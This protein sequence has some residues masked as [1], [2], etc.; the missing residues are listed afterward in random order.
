MEGEQNVSDLYGA[1]EDPQYAIQ[2]QAQR[3]LCG[4]GI[5]RIRHKGE[6]DRQA[7]QAILTAL[8]GDLSIGALERAVA[9]VKAHLEAAP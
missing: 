7:L 3:A 2:R 5:R 6:E 8:N 1:T 4:D 9:T